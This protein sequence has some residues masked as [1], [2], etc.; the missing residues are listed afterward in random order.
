MDSPD[1]CQTSQPRREAARMVRQ[2]WTDY[3][4]GAM[5]STSLARVRSAMTRLPFCL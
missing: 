1:S 3:A 2:R 5:S 4:G